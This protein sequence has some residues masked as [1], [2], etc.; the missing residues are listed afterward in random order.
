[1][2]C[3]SASKKKRTSVFERRA[4]DATRQS[5]ARASRRQGECSKI[6][7]LAGVEVVDESGSKLTLPVSAVSTAAV[8]EMSEEGFEAASATAMVATRSLDGP[9]PRE[10][11]KITVECDRGFLVYLVDLGSLPQVLYFARVESEKGLSVS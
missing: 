2:N 1:M 3:S 10:P 7:P 11:R 8:L 5:S 9:P 4:P 6:L